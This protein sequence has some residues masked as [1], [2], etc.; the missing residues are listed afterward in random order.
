MVS[1][2]I[3]SKEQILASYSDVYDGMDAFLIAHTIFRSIP[4]SHPSK[5]PG[6][7][8]GSFKKEIDKVLQVG[9][10]KP[11]NQATPWSNSFVL[12]G[13]KYKL[14]NLKLK[15][16]LDSTNLNKAIVCEPYHLKTPEDIVDLLAEA[17]VIAYCD[18]RKGYWHQKPDEAS[19]FLTTFNTKLGRFWYY[20]CR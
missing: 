7:L 10:L 9:V 3:T 18:C 8:K 2:L 15:I 4:V 19:S 11:V 5:P 20:H 17:C 1:N 12:V 13:G 6:H 14:R 16:C